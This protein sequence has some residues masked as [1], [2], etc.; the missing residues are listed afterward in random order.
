M[1]M[2][3]AYARP[4]A[5]PVLFVTGILVSRNGL[6]TETPVWWMRLTDRESAMVC[7]I[8]QQC[9]PFLM[10]LVTVDIFWLIDKFICVT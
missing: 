2:H 4:F 8:L 6:G 7:Q 3:F 9:V 5:L 10:G 1:A